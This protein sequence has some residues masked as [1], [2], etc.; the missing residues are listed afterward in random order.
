V[1]KSA[2][3]TLLSF[4]PNLAHVR[5]LTTAPS[6]RAGRQDAGSCKR[7]GSLSADHFYSHSTKGHLA[8]GLAAVDDKLAGVIVTLATFAVAAG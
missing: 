4:D 2:S 1:R 3:E 6:A 7:A 5:T 8:I